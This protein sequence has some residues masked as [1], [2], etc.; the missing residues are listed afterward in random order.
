MQWYKEAIKELSKRIKEVELKERSECT[1]AVFRC[2]FL[3]LPAA[4]YTGR[5]RYVTNGRKV[6]EGAG[7][8]TGVLVYDDGISW[9]RCS[10][11]TTVAA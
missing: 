3:D 8:G 6:G 1:D 2:A 10:D 4:G 5:L 9:V 11:D 7:L